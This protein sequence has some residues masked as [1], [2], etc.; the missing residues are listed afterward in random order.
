MIAVVGLF[1]IVNLFTNFKND[2]AEFKIRKNDQVCECDS[3][4]PDFYDMVG[5]L[6]YYGKIPDILDEK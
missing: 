6:S 2:K 4:V 3:Q 5:Q 1:A